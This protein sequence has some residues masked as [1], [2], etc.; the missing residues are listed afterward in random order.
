M[1]LLRELLSM[2]D[3]LILVREDVLLERAIRPIGSSIVV[4]FSSS[5]NSFALCLNQF[6]SL[7]NVQYTETQADLL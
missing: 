4:P 3:V 7:W 2:A 6:L 5:N 1:A